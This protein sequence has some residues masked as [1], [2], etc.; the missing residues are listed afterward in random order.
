MCSFEFNTKVS[1]PI[2][3]GSNSTSNHISRSQS[4]ATTSVAGDM[5]RSRSG[6]AGNSTGLRPQLPCSRSSSGMQ[7]SY[8]DHADA[9][10]VEDDGE[11]SLNDDQNNTHNVL[12][13]K[14]HAP[15]MNASRD[16]DDDE[17]H[18]KVSPSER[19][20]NTYQH[21]PSERQYLNDPH[22]P[23]LTIPYT[24]STLAA[25]R[26][27]ARP[28]SDRIVS[29]KNSGMKHHS[30]SAKLQPDDLDTIS[31]SSMQQERYKPHRRLSFP[32]PNGQQDD[33]PYSLHQTSNHNPKAISWRK[34][35]SIQNASAD[36]RK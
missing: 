22:D 24:A 30:L 17:E 7:E 16:F 26:T 9:Y 27:R 21:L 4:L 19:E 8:D 18:M 34:I 23:Q 35:P 5:S 12:Q 6:S 31:S 1:S 13:Q 29:Y 15:P 33:Y 20:G 11:D 28:Q 10:Q 32:S 2:Y 3:G 36:N 14:D 25:P